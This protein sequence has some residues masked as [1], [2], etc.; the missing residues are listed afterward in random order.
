MFEEIEFGN[1]KLYKIEG[2]MMQLSFLSFM[3][4]ILRLKKLSISLHFL[5]E[6]YCLLKFRSKSGLRKSVHLEA[7]RN[8]FYLLVSTTF[9]FIFIFIVE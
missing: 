6:C 9:L 2:F 1:L 7:Q 8:L 4:T 3:F 5:T